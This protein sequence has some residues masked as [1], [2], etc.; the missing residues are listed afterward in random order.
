MIM[1]EGYVPYKFKVGNKVIS[2]ILIN[3]FFFKKVG[4]IKK[5][6]RNDHHV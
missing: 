1:Y 6:L 2:F 5:Y 4:E 3:D